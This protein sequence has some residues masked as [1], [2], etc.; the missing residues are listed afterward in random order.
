[1]CLLR[2]TDWVWKYNSNIPFM[3][4]SNNMSLDL[5]IKQQPTYSG[6]VSAFQ[7]VFLAELLAESEFVYPERPATG[8]LSTGFLVLQLLPRA[9]HASLP[10]EIHQDYPPCFT[11]R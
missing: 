3:F 11:V 10:I 8:Q 6:N 1:V 9:S 5:P 4:S 2:G 7:S